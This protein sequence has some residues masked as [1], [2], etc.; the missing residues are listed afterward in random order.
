MK[1]GKNHIYEFYSHTMPTEITVTKSM[2]Y[3]Y[4][5]KYCNSGYDWFKTIHEYPDKIVNRLIICKK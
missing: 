4:C 3:Y 1:K 2:Y 5:T